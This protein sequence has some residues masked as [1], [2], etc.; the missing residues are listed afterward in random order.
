MSA[1]VLSTLFFGACRYVW[2]HYSFFGGDIGRNE[3]YANER[4]VV[5]VP[6]PR[7][8]THSTAH[9][10]DVDDFLL[11]AFSRHVN[12]GHFVISAAIIIYSFGSALGS[13]RVHIGQ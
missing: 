1:V 2:G 8:S 6:H 11:R 13:I 7:H 10:V 12:L 4:N 9:T 5:R 3:M